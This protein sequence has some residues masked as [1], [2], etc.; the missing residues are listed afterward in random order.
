[1]KKEL[2]RIKIAE[3]CGWKIERTTDAHGREIAQITEPDGNAY[4]WKFSDSGVFGNLP[5]YLNDL[6]AMAE[7]E[8]VLTE[9]QMFWYMRTLCRNATIQNPDNTLSVDE[10]R[11]MCFATAAQRAEVFLRT[12]GLW[13][14]E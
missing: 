11:Q 10:A 8:K 7:A 13:D 9:D 6:N 1:M 2:Q 3:A 5:D 14:A 4:Q 12:L